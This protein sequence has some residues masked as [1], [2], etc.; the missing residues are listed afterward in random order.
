MEVGRAIQID[1]PES[2]LGKIQGR[3]AG[4][5]MRDAQGFLPERSSMIDR[6]QE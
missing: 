5:P 1:V 3:N 4:I 6:R 2:G